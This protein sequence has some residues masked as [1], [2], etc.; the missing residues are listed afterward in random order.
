M[1]KQKFFLIF[2]ILLILFLVELVGQTTIDC[3][4]TS[5]DGSISGDPM[6]SGNYTNLRNASQGV[7]SYTG[8][9]ANIGQNYGGSYSIHRGYF[10]FDTRSIPSNATITN[11]VL[12][13]WGLFNHSD[14]EFDLCIVQSTQQSTGSLISSDYPRVST[15]IGGYKS[16]S[17]FSNTSYN[18]ITLNTTGKSWIAKGSYTKLA[19]RS[20][21][22]INASAPTNAEWVSVYSKESSHPPILTITYEIAEP[23]VQPN[24]VAIDAYIT[25]YGIA[26]Q[27]LTRDP[28]VG[29]RIQFGLDYRLDDADINSSYWV[30]CYLDNQLKWEQQYS[31]LSTGNKYLDPTLVGVT[32]TATE[33]NHELKWVLDSNDDIS[34]SNESDNIDTRTW[35]TPPQFDLQK[36]IVELKDVNGNNIQGYIGEEVYFHF[37]YSV[38][39]SG[40]TP[41][42]RIRCYLDWSTYYTSSYLTRTGGQSYTISAPNPWTATAGSHNIAWELDFENSID[43]SHEDNNYSE[44]GYTTKNRPP[45]PQLS[46]PG[47]GDNI[48]DTTPDFSWD[49]PGDINYWH[50]QIDNNLG[51]LSPYVR[52]ETQCWVN[53]WSPQEELNNETY[54]WRVRAHGTNDIWSEW[55]DPR[56][57][58]IGTTP[59]FTLL[60]PINNYTVTT[61][62]V[63]FQWSDVSAVKY[64]IEV[65]DDDNFSS[66][67]ISKQ[68]YSV[69]NNLNINNLTE[70]QFEIFGNWLPKL[71]NNFPYYWRVKAIYS[72]NSSQWSE[73]GTFIYNPPV[74]DNPKWHPLYRVYNPQIKDHFYCANDNHRQIALDDGYQSER[75]DGFVSI[76]RFNAP[77][78]VP[79]YRFWINP[80]KCHYY[81]AS[82]S[83]RDQQIINGLL[84]EGIVGF[85]YSTSAPGFTPL[86]HI[87]K[88]WAIPDNPDNGDHCYTVSEYEK[89]YAIQN[90][91]FIDQGITVY[92]SATGENLYIPSH[93]SQ[94]NLGDG[95]N[96]LT[97]NF[98]H[99]TK[100]SF[101][102]SSIGMP[103]IFA[104][105]YNSLAVFL[106]S[107][108][109]PLG[110][111]WSHSYLAYID[112][113]Y[114]VNQVQVVWPDGRIDDYDKNGSTFTPE[115]KF[116]YDEL[117]Q[118]SSTKYQ[119]KKKDQTRFIFEVPSGADDDYPAMLTE[120]IDRNNNKITL[121]YESSGLFRLVSVTDPANRQLSISYYTDAGKL[122]LIKRV[123]DNASRYIE[124]EY[125]T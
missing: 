81:T 107:Q 98:Q 120:I 123:T 52:E 113:A 35:Y 32:W 16:T 66:P 80:E 95:M 84:Y 109:M 51:F 105:T 23:P 59:N 76:V 21:E 83:D 64:E 38:S 47:S 110:P 10:P 75:T 88:T 24:L 79:I 56:S 69:L 11:A 4:T 112:F 2:F 63:T 20:R 43:E 36:G 46:Y 5:G 96:P 28:L 97:G 104:H 25:L 60:S 1:L 33:G 91:Q 67:E 49:N 77:D 44:T 94:L 13:V 87:H 18:Q 89:N 115:Y 117:T 7:P 108:M 103:L 14:T 57:F 71:N 121:N 93:Q 54:Y 30:K 99:Y 27:K 86:Y 17:S 119:I 37:N 65:D 61:D 106:K 50:I 39:G 41:Q 55:S 114:S 26:W 111:G 6:Y 101:Y 78:M 62:E 15:T 29:E 48:T 73:I 3:Y 53:W 70:T 34:E 40:T 22:D 12:K 19:I 42:F 100:S 92:V 82:E 122:Q 45:K 118:I 125:N 68:H 58:T 116:V 8:S 72:D 85:G 74:S 31:Y 124:F 102:I 90:Y 9:G